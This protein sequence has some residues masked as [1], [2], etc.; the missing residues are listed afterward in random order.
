MGKYN[1]SIGAGLFLKISVIEEVIKKVKKDMRIRTLD[2]PKQEVIT[3]D[4]ISVKIDAV[5]FMKVVDSLKS[6][7][8]IQDSEYSVKQY[9]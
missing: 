4:N 7:V 5:V 2:I 8:K 1:R 6:I 3:K 9:A